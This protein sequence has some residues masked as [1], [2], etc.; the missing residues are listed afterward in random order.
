MKHSI[1]IFHGEKICEK[2]RMTEAYFTS[3][4][5]NMRLVNEVAEL[6]KEGK[7]DYKGRRWYLV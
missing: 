6:V 2:C 3:E 4:C 5:S 7:I 1:I